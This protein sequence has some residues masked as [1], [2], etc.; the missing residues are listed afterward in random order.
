MSSPPTLTDTT[1]LVHSGFLKASRNTT[2]DLPLWPTQRVPRA[3]PDHAP[4]SSR[5]DCLSILKVPVIR[6]TLD[7]STDLLPLDTWSRNASSSPG[8]FSVSPSSYMSMCL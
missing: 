1:T 5:T 7:S 2:M 8:M 6:P 3:P 4:P